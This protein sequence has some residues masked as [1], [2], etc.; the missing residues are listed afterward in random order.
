VTEDLEKLGWAPLLARLDADLARAE[1][2]RSGRRDRAAW[3][4]LL[5]RLGHYA[6]I[7][8]RKPPPRTGPDPWLAEDEWEPQDIAQEVFVKL[9]ARNVLAKLRRARK[10]AGYLVAMLRNAEADRLDPS[11]RSVALER[12]EPYLPADV[13]FIDPSTR[14][15]AL[16]QALTQ[17]SQKERA[18]LGA[19]YDEHHERKR[20][21]R[22]IADTLGI[23][24][25]AAAVRLHRLR[26]HLRKLMTRKQTL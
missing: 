8:A 22:E 16:Q 21:V 19:S 2:D 6:G 10:P 17:L 9:H 25:S 14:G 4:E 26:K 11:H 5:R 18:L 1:A 7:A 24:Y 20:S 23:S 3:K 13:P 15:R 12:L